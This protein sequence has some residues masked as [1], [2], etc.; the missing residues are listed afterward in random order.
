MA[1]PPLAT[2]S[3]GDN[4]MDRAHLL[5]SEVL[6]QCLEYDASSGI[7]TRKSRPREHFANLRAWR[8]YEGRFANALAGC[9]DISNG[10]VKVVLVV[11]QRIYRSYAHQ[12][13]WTMMTG[14]SLSMKIDHIDRNRLNN[15]WN[16]LRIAT[17]SQNGQ[18]RPVAKSSLTQLKGVLTRHKR[19]G[20][21]ARIKG[22]GKAL[23]LGIFPTAEEAHAA[24]CK[25]A[26]ELHGEF[27]NP[28]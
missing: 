25:A 26:R 15:K 12:I 9:V 21:E 5:P 6:H 28:G 16:N 17:D 7:L 22:N 10:Y 14:K 1:A 4:A 20:Y 27:W 18:N 11:D 24:Y 19:P 13:I 8:G 3:M 23:R 2:A